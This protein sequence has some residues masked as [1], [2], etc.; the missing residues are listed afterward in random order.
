MGNLKSERTVA[1]DVAK[2]HP[3][4]IQLGRTLNSRLVLG[5]GLNTAS[6]CERRCLLR[7][8]NHNQKRVRFGE[9]G[10]RIFHFSQLE[11][12]E[13]GTGLAPVLN[14][15]CMTSRVVPHISP[16]FS[17]R[18]CRIFDRCIHSM[19]FACFVYMCVWVRVIYIFSS[20]TF[21]STEYGV[22]RWGPRL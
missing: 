19:G 12:T 2:L 16:I 5:L 10:V 8:V 3:K 1:D 22:R 18:E 17:L 4:G 13:G 11:A 15:A 14:K 6:L 7:A 9:K 20:K 21:A